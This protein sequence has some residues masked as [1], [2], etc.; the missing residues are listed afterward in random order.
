MWYNRGMATPPEV[1]LAED[2]RVM[3]RS[4]AAVLR[5]GGFAVREAK[6]G[7]DAVAAFDVRRPD[8]VVLDLM[9]PKTD[10]LA[11]CREIRAR[12]A[13]VPV[14]F[15]TGVPSETKQLRAYEDGADDYVMKSANPD[16]L[17]AKV[18]AAAR[19]AAAQAAPAAAGRLRLGSVEVDLR[20][21]E[22]LFSGVPSGR[23]TR[24]ERDILEIL[25]SRRGQPFSCDELISALRGE[26]FACEDA[27]VYVH[28]SNLRKK[29]GKAAA[30]LTS[31]RDSGYAL[32]P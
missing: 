11:A 17:V 4:F 20:S 27:M 25:A 3:R 8:V 24:T 15:L 26:G 10:G 28:V 14:I 29:L 7:A 30:M 31:A 32:L 9:M 12:D 2:D 1:L 19:R 6:D 13:L 16:L 21:S 22:V 5:S 23:L 18:R